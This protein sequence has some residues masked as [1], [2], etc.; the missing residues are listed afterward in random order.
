MIKNESESR[1]EGSER[2]GSLRFGSMTSERHVISDRFRKIVRF[3]IEVD[4]QG[5]LGKEKNGTREVYAK[6]RETIYFTLW[7]LVEMNE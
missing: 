2:K 1:K 5:I 3:W 4:G 6:R 7:S